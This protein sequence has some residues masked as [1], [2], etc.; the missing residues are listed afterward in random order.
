MDRSAVAGQRRFRRGRTSCRRPCR[1]GRCACRSSRARRCVPAHVPAQAPNRRTRDARTDR[2]RSPHRQ[3]VSAGGCAS[4]CDSRDPARSGPRRRVRH[5][6]GC[7]R[8]RRRPC[9]S[10]VRPRPPA[11]CPGSVPPAGC[12]CRRGWP[13]TPSSRAG[14]RPAS[15]A[16]RPHRP[17]ARRRKSPRA[18]SP[19]HARALGCGR[20]GRRNRAGDGTCAKYRS[21]P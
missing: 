10:R 1:S 20:R 11:A 14:L 4:A 8:R 18:G 16:G 3:Q 21:R 15:F 17:R 12:A 5:R 13:S 2:F 9:R 6:A 7:P 19:P